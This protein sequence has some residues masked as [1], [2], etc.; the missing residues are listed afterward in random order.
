MTPFLSSRQI[1]RIFIGLYLCLFFAYLFLPLLYMS[2]AAFND[3]RLPAAVPW[4]G[5]TLQW[6]GDLF[7]DSMLWDSLVNSILVGIGVV[8]LSIPIGLNAALLLHSL[9]KRA[10]TFTYGIMVSP[11]LMPG[12]ILGISTLVFWRGF[13]IGGG[14][15]LSIF[16]QTTFIA[17]YCLMMFQARLQRL[18]PNWEEAA[19]DLGASHLQVMRR[20]ILPFLMPTAIGA[21]VIA[22]LQSFENYNT[23]LFVYGSDRTLTIYLAGKVRIGLTPAVNALS[24]I[25]ILLTVLAAVL[26]EWRRRA[27]MRPARKRR[28]AAATTIDQA[29]PVPAE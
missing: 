25:F 18:D 7:K 11:I 24:V 14:L 22:F 2:A 15:H 21:A 23:T 1:L 27:E 17:S 20:I 26:Y 8:A 4:Q 5:F 19:L 9:E 16:A 10:R 6:F 29:A 12:V 28:A 13:D 3:S